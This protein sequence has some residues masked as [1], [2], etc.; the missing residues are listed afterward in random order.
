MCTAQA[1]R[2]DHL[3]SWLEV[4]LIVRALPAPAAFVHGALAHF[5]IQNTATSTSTA[6]ATRGIWNGITWIQTAVVRI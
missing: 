2:E 5:V 3:L 4:V 6:V 1:A